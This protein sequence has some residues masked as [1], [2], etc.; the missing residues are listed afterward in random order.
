MNCWE[1]MKCGN[2]EGGINADKWGV[3]PA[4]PDYGVSC[5][6]VVGTL[7]ANKVQGT[8]A[9]KRKMCK[10][11][12]FYNSIYYDKSDDGVNIVIVNDA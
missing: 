5:A 8:S 3:C 9:Q 7:C 2:E 11:C 1:F 4:Y 12:K 6:R 10:P